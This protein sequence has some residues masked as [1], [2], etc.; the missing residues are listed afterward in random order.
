ML[1]P[2]VEPSGSPLGHFW[3]PFWRYPGALFEV[4]SR[5]AG[6]LKNLENLIKTFFFEV[7]GGSKI[8][9]NRVRKQLPAATELKE[10]SW[11]RFLR[12]L[13]AMLGSKID[14]TSGR[15]TS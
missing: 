15:K 9:P 4:P 13:G 8:N 11:G 12:L 3:G 7:P 6:F 14:P 5:E 10:G 2:Y 1:K